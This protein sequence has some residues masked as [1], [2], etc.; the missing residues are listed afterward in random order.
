M[1]MS[2]ASYPG[3]TASIVTSTNLDKFIPEIWSDEVI[4]A[5]KKRLVMGNLVSKMPFTGK[6]G[7][8][9]HIPMPTRGAAYAKAAGTAVTLQGNVESEITVVVNK[10]YEYSR[11]IEDFAAVQALSSHRSFYTKDAGYQ[12][13]KQIDFDLMKL[14]RV[15]F[16][17][18]DG[19]GTGDPVSAANLDPYAAAY[20]GGDGTTVYSSASTGNATA[21]TDA[22]IR[23]IIQRL[24]DADVPFEDR[25]LVIPPSAKNTLLGLSRFTEQAFVG[26]SASGNTI[27]NGQIGN[28]YG[29]D[30]YTTTN[31]EYAKVASGTAYPRIALMFHSDSLVLAMQQNIRT[32]TQYKQEYLATLLTADTI[33]G[34]KG[35]RTS[36]TSGAP[37]EAG[38]FAIAVPG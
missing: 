37:N 15:A 9:L 19:G 28:I 17:G 29:I 24:D 8:T 10:H 21:L 1:A 18:T 32:Q 38:Y 7:D 26:E 33:Y 22:G 27:R 3:G 35:I 2:T 23:R 34:V 14:G 20:I 4:A 6:K 13:A 31:C 12:L 30:V 11:F 16:G 25:H 5:F 36:S